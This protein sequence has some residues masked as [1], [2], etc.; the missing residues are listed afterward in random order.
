MMVRQE[1]RQKKKPSKTA[2]ILHLGI[3]PQFEF[4]ISEL[5]PN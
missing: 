1:A 3:K 5:T 2:Q 4:S